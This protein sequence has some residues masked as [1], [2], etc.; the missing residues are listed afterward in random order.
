MG[1]SRPFREG[2]FQGA[3]VALLVC[4]RGFQW[5]SRVF[6]GISGVFRGFSRGLRSAPWRLRGVTGDFIRVPGDFRGDYLD[7]RNIP[8]VPEGLRV[9]QRTSSVFICVPR[10]FQDNFK[11]VSEGSLN[12]R[13][14]QRHSIDFTSV[15]LGFTGVPEVFKR[16]QGC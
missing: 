7:F 10:E 14:F 2:V 3:S 11:G 12:F 16:L 13:E 9:F 5:V 4:S 1:S 15:L 8:R 6:Q